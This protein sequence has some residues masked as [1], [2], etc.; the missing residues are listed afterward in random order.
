MSV[1]DKF[2]IFR[3]TASLQLGYVLVL[4]RIIIFLNIQCKNKDVVQSNF[5]ISFMNRGKT[6][7]NVCFY[8]KFLVNIS[9]RF[10]IFIPGKKWSK[11]YEQ[12]RL[13]KEKHYGYI[14]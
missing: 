13:G 2:N 12:K 5:F 14:P 3:S 7:L 8:V 11:L 9:C 4:L 6:Q 1:F 10:I